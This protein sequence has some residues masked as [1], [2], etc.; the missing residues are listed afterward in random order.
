MIQRYHHP[1]CRLFHN[2]ALK[3]RTP[4]PKNHLART[5]RG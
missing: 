5:K 1:P 3:A 4:Y 2:V